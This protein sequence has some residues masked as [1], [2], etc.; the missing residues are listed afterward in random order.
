MKDSRKTKERLIIEIKELRESL[1]KQISERN[2]VENA[3][4]ESEGKYRKLI[5][6]ANDAIFIADAESG[7]ILD[8]NR[9]AE[10]MMNM[11]AEE[12]IGMHQKEL[13]PEDKAGDYKQIFREYVRNGDGISDEVVVCRKDGHKIPVEI[14]A[15]VIEWG[16]KKVVQGI[17]RDITRRK[18]VEDALTQS[19]EQMQYILDNT[20]S[21]IY[22]KDA[23]GKYIIVN[24]QFLDLF[25]ITKEEIIGKTNHDIF[26]KEMADTFQAN[27]RKVLKAQAPLEIEEVALH[28]DGRHTYISIKFPLLDSKGIA[29]GVCG[30]STDITERKKAEKRLEVQKEALEQKNLALSEILGQIEIEKKQIK[31]DV[32]ANAENLLLPIIQKLRLTGESRKYVLLLRKNLQELTSSFGTKLT[33]KG[34]KLTSREVEVCG[35]IKNGLTSKEI[36]GLLNISLRTVETHRIKIR[37][38]L[39]I[40]NKDLNLSSYLKTL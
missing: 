11:P 9:R 32:I 13:H 36:A 8:V 20:T 33:E 37:N 29:C 24:R 25:H 7:I 12:I 6:T 21:V 14:S 23:Q 31:D 40:V 28:D 2:R 22:I 30:I 16:G 3:L 15:S 1:E 38:K 19:K 39:G 4:S 10:E 27:D 5:E 35:M 26:P 18:R 34:A 17:F